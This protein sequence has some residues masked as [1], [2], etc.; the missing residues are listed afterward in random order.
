MAYYLGRDIT[1]YLTTES[2]EAQVDVVSNKV[3]TGEAGGGSGAAATATITFTGIPDLDEEIT[4]I[5]N[6]IKIKPVI[7]LIPS[8]NF[9]M[10]RPVFLWFLILL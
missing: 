5:A 6:K 2:T 10:N 8:I 4:I 7:K 9:P 1:V 3:S